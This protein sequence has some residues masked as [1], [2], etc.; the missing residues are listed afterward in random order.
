MRLWGEYGGEENAAGGDME[1]VEVKLDEAGTRN[2]S[3]LQ[4]HYQGQGHLL[5]AQGL[6]CPGPFPDTGAVVLCFLS[7]R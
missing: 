5:S 4:L 2:S 3:T 6:S 1:T 7:W